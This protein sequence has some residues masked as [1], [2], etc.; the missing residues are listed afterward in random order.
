ME[1]PDQELFLPDLEKER[2]EPTALERLRAVLFFFGAAVALAGMVYLSGFYQFFLF[3]RTS[4]EA[5]QKPLPSLVEGELLV[6][7]LHAFVL[8]QEPTLGSSRQ[9]DDV[10]RIVSDASAIWKQANISFTVDSISFVEVE[11]EELGLFLADPRMFLL[12]I[13]GED[14]GVINVFLTKTLSGINGV[15]FTDVSSL[16]VADFTTS[17]D[18]RVLAHEIGHVLS[19]PH[20]TSDGGR[21]MFQGADGFLLTQDEA[22]R[23]RVVARR[24]L[25]ADF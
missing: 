8:I 6:L 24:F 25:G 23:A 21:L 2:K 16:V 14:L 7:P 3:S 10:K 19:L 18:F 15:A 12:G 17:F 9:E 11:K 4:P 1:I 20:V 13:S 22:L 5:H